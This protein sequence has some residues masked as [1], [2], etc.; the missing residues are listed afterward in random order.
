MWK[1]LAWVLWLAALPLIGCA[2]NVAAPPQAAVTPSA[3]AST[4]TLFS[5]AAC[6]CGRH[7]GTG[8]RSSVA[9]G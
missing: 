5:I 7:L 3:A 9:A 6:L 1:V 8:C 4:A 2:G